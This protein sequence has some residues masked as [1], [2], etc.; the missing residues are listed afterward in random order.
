MLYALL[1]TQAQGQMDAG[2]PRAYALTKE[3]DVRFRKRKGKTDP[4]W[5][6]PSL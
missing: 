5:S 2:N 3:R 4:W 6:L 1:F